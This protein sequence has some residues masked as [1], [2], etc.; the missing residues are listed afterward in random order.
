MKDNRQYHLIKGISKIICMLPYSWVLALG[1]VLGSVYYRT[2][3]RQRRRAILQMQTSLKL[4]ISE[5]EK[6]VN[7]MCVKLA[8]AVLE[9]LYTPRLTKATIREYVE[10]ENEQYLWE[11]LA[12]GRGIVFVTAHFGNWE[13]MGAALSLLGVPVASIVRRQPNE[14]HTRLLNEFRGMSGIEVFASGTNE[15]IAAAKALKKGKLLGFLADQ[16]AGC[17]GIMLDF[18]GQP[19]STPP[20]PAVF[21]KKIN[22]PVVPGFIMRKPNGR[23]LLKIFP[24]LAY[25]DT[26]DELNDVGNF[27]IQVNTILETMIRD[28]PDEW[29]WIQ[30]RWNTTAEEV[31]RRS[32]FAAFQSPVN[33]RVEHTQ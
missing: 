33:E 26:G 30:K 16:D 17:T 14:Q 6:H 10:I 3:A 1:S 19:A 32:R 8:Q 31:Q 23:H 24:P 12:Q 25:V 5:C 21:A 28:Y 15:L 18:L 9:I 7:S 4:P 11:A 27:M 22:A 2:A 13:W 20:G 29:L